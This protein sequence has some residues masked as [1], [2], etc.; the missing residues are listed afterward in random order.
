MAT[1]VAPATPPGLQPHHPA[2]IHSPDTHFFAELSNVASAAVGAR[3]LFATDDWFACA[4]NM[5]SDAPPV[6]DPDAFTNWGKTMD[7]WETR[8]KRIAGHDWCVLRLGLPA[9]IRG[10]VIDTGFFTGNQCPAVSVHACCIAENS[11]AAHALEMA[12]DWEG[13]E[14][15]GGFCAGGTALAAAAALD[16]EGC[17]SE[18]LPHTK[19]DPG[20]EGTR[21]HFLAVGQS[22]AA[23]PGGQPGWTHLRVNMWPDGG[24]SRLRVMGEVAAGEVASGGGGRALVDTAAVQN[25]GVAIEA[26]NKHYGRPANLIAPGRAAQVRALPRPRAC[27]ECIQHSWMDVFTGIVPA[28]SWSSRRRSTAVDAPLSSDAVAVADGAHRTD[29]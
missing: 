26:S 8:R 23:P 11:A 21:L 28:C 29:G 10:L 2:E 4:E 5:I 6:F 22:V 3:V 27:R 18:I 12:R 17:W 7:G 14:G 13:V 25:G 16:A 9:V 15:G 24:I 1:V 20:Y 19:L